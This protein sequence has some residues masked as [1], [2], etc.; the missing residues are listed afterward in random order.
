MEPTG[1]EPATPSLQS[2]EHRTQAP[3]N[4]G[5][6]TGPADACTAACTDKPEIEHG[7]DFADVVR[8]LDRLPLTDAER[9]EAVRQLLG[10]GR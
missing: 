9:A 3:Q 8:M 7:G 10:R 1:I 5:L 6:A 2:C 4:Q